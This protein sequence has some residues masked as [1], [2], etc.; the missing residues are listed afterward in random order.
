[1]DAAIAAY[2]RE[3]IRLQAAARAVDLVARALRGQRWAARL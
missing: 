1:M 3:R 2:E